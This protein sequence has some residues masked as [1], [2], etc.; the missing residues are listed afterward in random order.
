M[1]TTSLAVALAS[2]LLGQVFAAPALMAQAAG[3]PAVTGQATAAA[4]PAVSLL[5]AAKTGDSAA[6]L[7]LVK[8][9][10]DVNAAEADGT[11]ALHWAVYR[12]DTALVQALLAAGAKVNV[13]NE[14]GSSPLSEAAIT[15]NVAVIDALLK[16]GADPESPNADGQT[17]LMV[18]A[19]TSNLEAAKLLLKKGANA[20]AVEKWHGQTA[21]MWAAAQE[22]PEMVKLLVKHGANVNARSL[23]NNWQRQVTAEPR[24]QARPAGGLTPL[25][26]AAR[27]G[28]LGCV[29]ALVE[30]KADIDMADPEGVTPLIIAVNNFHFDV[31]AY[32]LKHGA[33]PNKWDWW[34]RTP[35]YLAVDLNTVP[36]GGRPDRISLD[37]TTSLKMI[38]LLLEAGANPN[39][40]LKLF[41]PYR[42]LGPDR[43]ADLMLTMGATPLLRAA[44]AGDVPAIKLLLAHGANP[45]L[46]NIYGTTPLMA[47][48]GLS[49][50]EI[51]TRGR[52][53]TQEEAVESINLLVAAGAD[54][55]A[56]E[57]RTCPPNSSTCASGQTALH[58]AAL[59]GWNDVIKALVAHNAD[60]NAKDDKGHTPLDSA[61]GKAGGHGRGGTRIEVHEQTAALIRELAA[62]SPTKAQL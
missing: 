15:G 58:G 54:V 31:G 34:G 53:K 57:T 60:L 1:R 50:N 46:P 36:H 18:L 48:A 26:Y 20:N 43:G 30:G 27:Q 17:A 47:A 7:D 12:N 33:N 8:H 2:A 39:A 32:L 35:L 28:C 21:L 40:Q 52:F 19:R 25:L 13:T 38:E 24:A 56:R 14:F 5:E 59:W 41:P 44:K 16:A 4:H 45:N 23:V 62:A 55:N 9:G 10:A 42:A 51:D 37:Q 61:L 49:S 6:A 11:T 29:Q 3:T 22:Q